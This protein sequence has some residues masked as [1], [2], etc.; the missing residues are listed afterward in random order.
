MQH[1]PKS[2]GVVVVEHEDGV[3][4]IL[5]VPRRSACV[6]GERVEDLTGDRE[7]GDDG[8]HDETSFAS[9]ARCA[10]HVE[11]PREKKC[12]RDVRRCRKEQPAVDAVEM[13]GGQDVRRRDFGAVD[14]TREERRGDGQ[15]V[16]DNG[17]ASIARRR[18][19]F[20][21][22]R[23]FDALFGRVMRN[24]RNVARAERSGGVGKLGHDARPERCAGREHAVKARERIAGRRHERAESCDALYRRHHATP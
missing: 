11:C 9:R 2:S 17:A 24:V 20:Q 19:F 10:V 21:L 7:V 6:T 8:A 18:S 4:R 5:L 13:R 3:L 12:P 16:G 14:V 1:A 23:L 15:G 22:A